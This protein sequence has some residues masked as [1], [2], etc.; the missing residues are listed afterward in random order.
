MTATPRLAFNGSSSTGYAYS[1]GAAANGPNVFSIGAWFKTPT[2]NGGKIVG[3]GSSQTGNSGSYDRQIYLDNSGHVV[4]GVYNHNTVATIR[5]TGTY[6]D[7]NWHQVVA[8]LSGAGMALYVDGALVRHQHQTYVGPGLH[9]LLADRRRQPE[10]L[11]ERAAQQLLQRFD[12]RRRDLP[13]RADRQPRCASS[14]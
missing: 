2:S 4:F 12:R 5:S 10:R 9:G 1:S 8:T 11:A 14:T 13:V 7:G 3:F 6:R